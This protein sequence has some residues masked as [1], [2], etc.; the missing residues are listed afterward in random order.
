LKW[1]CIKRRAIELY[2]KE[3]YPVFYLYSIKNKYKFNY[4]LKNKNSDE[5]RRIDTECCLFTA[6]A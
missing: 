5:E 1:N 4:L 2:R 3:G 6:K